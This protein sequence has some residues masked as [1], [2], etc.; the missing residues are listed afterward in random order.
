MDDLWF[1]ISFV[2]LLVCVGGT[3]TAHWTSVIIIII[4][5]IIHSLPAIGRHPVAAVVTCYIS[6]TMK[7]LL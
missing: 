5:I 7:I 2:R 3:D 1:D 4:I 6:T